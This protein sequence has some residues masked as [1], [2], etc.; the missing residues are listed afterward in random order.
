[1]DR[2]WFQ[3]RSTTQER[4]NQLRQYQKELDLQRFD[5]V[6]TVVFKEGIYLLDKSDE[7]WWWSSGVSSGVC[8]DLNR[9]LQEEPRTGWED[10]QQKEESRSQLRQTQI[11]LIFL[12]DDPSWS[13]SDRLDVPEKI[14]EDLQRR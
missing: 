2:S 14:K 12:T 9:S 11:L 8:Q 10:M 5:I 7:T 6:N 13:E 1:M 3:D 4:V